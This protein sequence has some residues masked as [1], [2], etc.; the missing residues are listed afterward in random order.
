MKTPTIS[1][2]DL[3]SAVS[4]LAPT[5]SGRFLLPG[6]AAYDDARRVHNGLIDK[7]PAVIA[8]C[9]G[10]VDIA[11]SIRLAQSLG[12]ELAVR[13]GGHNVAGR[14]TIDGG[15]MIDLSLMRSVLVDPA[16]RTA[17]AEGGATWKE[18]NRETQ[19]FGLATTGGVV[20]T[21]GIA[22]LT[23]GGGLG[24]LMAKHGMALDNLA[25]VDVVLADGKVVR[26]SDDEN[27]D[28]FWA[29]RGGGG[30]FGVASSFT[31]RLHDVGPTI[32]GGLCA[33]PF[34]RARDVLR[35]FRDLTAALPD[36]MM[37][38]AGLGTAP[39]GKTKIVLIA[40][41]HCGT[42]SAGAAAVKPIKAFGS[43]ILDVLGPMPYAQL[44]GML[45]DGFPKGAL[46]YWKTNFIDVLSDGAID[47]A[48]ARFASCPSPM[49]KVLFEHFHGA[50]TRVPVGATAYALR[51]AGFNTLILGQWLDPRQTDAS[52]GWVRDIHAAL[53]PFVGKRRYV[54]YLSDDDANDAALTAAY[55]PN[56]QRLRRIKST[57]DPENVFRHNI[58]IRPG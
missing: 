37:L 20:G 5:F 45:D 46:N 7:R 11:E 53:Q 38:M 31:L 58:N 30:N 43:P 13:G 10:T 21:T 34:E 14:A 25:A 27:A 44:N 48:I 15:V 40:A 8:Q 35:S 49:T 41:C 52:I 50:A 32:T 16:S 3:S 29:I 17:R 28:L 19:Q 47:A 55:G 18:F 54:N 9:R 26:A 36:E 6:D 1:R 51:G 24:W 2:V 57:V 23:L 42:A 22:G 56:L 4:A 12:L 39:D 33:W